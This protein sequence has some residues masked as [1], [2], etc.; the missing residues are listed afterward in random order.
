MDERDVDALARLVAGSES[1]RAALRLL[2]GG[3][4]GGLAARLGLAEGAAARPK[5]QHKR[6]PE[7]KSRETLQT[8]GKRKGKG[9]GKKAGKK[10]PQPPQPQ[11]EPCGPG[12]HRCGPGPCIPINQCCSNQKRCDDGSCVAE[13]GCCLGLKRC[14]DACIPADECCWDDLPPL[15]GGGCQRVVCES[16]QLRC[17]PLPLGAPC[18]TSRREDGTCCNGQCTREALICPTYP[19]RVFNTATCQCECPNGSTDDRFFHG[20]CCPAGYPVS[21]QAGWCCPEE[22]GNCV[23]HMGHHSCREGPSGCCRD[24]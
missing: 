10:R 11:P 22:G 2:A 8:E 12:E 13:D 14:D 15:C 9:K 18:R 24:S 19:W 5:K 7:S 17:E 4:L 20:Y 16:G 3:A 6:R 1:R 21:N 23:C